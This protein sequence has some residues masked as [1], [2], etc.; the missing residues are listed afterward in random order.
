MI[1]IDVLVD[2][3]PARLAELIHS[4]EER[5]GL[6]RGEAAEFLKEGGKGNGLVHRVL[7]QRVRRFGAGD[8][9]GGPTAHEGNAGIQG[10]DRVFSYDDLP[11]GALLPG[12]QNV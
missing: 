3:Q 9:D 6:P 4:G 1:E 7:E 5:G 11:H 8:M 2:D 10:G 12:L